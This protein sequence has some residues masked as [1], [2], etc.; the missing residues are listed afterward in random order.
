MKNADIK[1]QGYLLTGNNK[2]LEPRTMENHFHKILDE[3]SIRQ[4]NF[5]TLRH[6]FATR[7]IEVGFDIKSLSEILGHANVNI[8]L[9]RYV[10]P[11][12]QLK[13]ENMERLSVFAVK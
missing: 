8:T 6:T 11:P 1:R 4:V 9:N 12:L 13:K 10:H 5:H 2:Y 3:I 7:C